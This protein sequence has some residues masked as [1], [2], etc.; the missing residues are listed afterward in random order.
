MVTDSIFDDILKKRLIFVSGKGGVGKTTVAIVLALQASRQKKNTLIVE[1]NSAGQVAPFF[2]GVPETQTSLHNE[3]PL[4][5]YITGVTLNPHI[6]FE[7]YVLRRIKFKAIYKTFFDNQLVT[8]FIGAVPGL[9]EILMLGKIFDLER[10]KKDKLSSENKYDL[11]VVDAPA[12][13]HGLSALEVP[14]VI[15]SA[16]K[17]GPL[18]WHARD[19]TVLLQDK[20]KTCFCLVT[21]AEEMPVSESLDYLRTLREKNLIPT[22]PVFINAVM[23]NVEKVKRPQK[24]PET[25]RAVWDFYSLA[26]ERAALNEHYC[27][28]LKKNLTE[29]SFFIVPFSFKTLTEH[30]DYEKLLEQIQVSP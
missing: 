24:L 28:E 27:D 22:G 13:G 18:S 19:T 7:E 15:L 17:I 23:P 25:I 8:N 3:I 29:C 9:N 4:A 10:Q 12:T 5:P 1:M 11:I 16:V 20:N 21:L 26:R 30:A 2:R 14:Q 6:C